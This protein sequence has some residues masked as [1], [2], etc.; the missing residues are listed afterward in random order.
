MLGLN[1]FWRKLDFA[2]LPL[3]IGVNAFF[4]LYLDWQNKIWQ[5]SVQFY[6]NGIGI[7]N[8]HHWLQDVKG[9]N[10]TKMKNRNKNKSKQTENKTRQSKEKKRLNDGIHLDING[11]ISSK[12]GTVADITAPCVSIQIW[13]TMT[14]I[15]S[16]SHMIKQQIL[17]SCSCT[18][19]SWCAEIGY[20][21]TVFGFL[22]PMKSFLFT[23][24]ILKEEKST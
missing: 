6:R 4:F 10:E 15:Q 24:L 20:A 22:K 8:F 11:T 16:L 5:Y 7:Q 1:T 23:W 2:F 3:S 19:F 13:M 14:F 17:C 21:A 12:F 18:F 9:K